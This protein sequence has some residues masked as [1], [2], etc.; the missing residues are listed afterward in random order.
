MI[1]PQRLASAICHFLIA[2]MIQ[3]ASEQVKAQHDM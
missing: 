1:G 3:M 2:A